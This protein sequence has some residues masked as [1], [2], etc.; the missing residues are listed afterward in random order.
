MIIF[1]ENI[2]F[3]MYNSLSNITQNGQNSQY[4]LDFICQLEGWKT[5]CKNLH[6]SA[7]NEMIHARLDEFL[8]IISD[9]QDSL[10]EEMMG[11]FGKLNPNDVQGVSTNFNTAMEF[12]SAV[13]MNTLKY[14]RGIPQTPDFAGLKSECE[15]FIH[16][17]NKYTY[18]FSL[19]FY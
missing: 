11:I 1:E 3:H 8:D 14:Y 9:F 19:C 15:S 10:A 18:L 2:L 5:K 16:E 17:I 4:F 7:P 6:W 13:K 12:I